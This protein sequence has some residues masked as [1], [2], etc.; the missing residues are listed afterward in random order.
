MFALH[1][2]VKGEWCGFIVA[3]PWM[4]A[5]VAKT[6]MQAKNVAAAVT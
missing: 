3:L 5:A 4:E 6:S 1:R 2:A